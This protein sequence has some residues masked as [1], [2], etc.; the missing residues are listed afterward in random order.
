M[1]KGIQPDMSHENFET[2]APVNATPQLPACELPSLDR[3]RTQAIM[4]AILYVGQKPAYDSE[5]AV[6]AALKIAAEL[7]LRIEQEEHDYLRRRSG[8]EIYMRSSVQ[9]QE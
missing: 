2:N 7:L 5:T 8:D 9:S 1:L 3:I 4:A 6:K